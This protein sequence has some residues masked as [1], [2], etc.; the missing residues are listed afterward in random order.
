MI[1]LEQHI[2][3]LL[4]DHDYVVV[5]RFGGFMARYTSARFDEAEDRLLPPTRSLSFNPR[6]QLNDGLLVQSYMQAYGTDFP[7]ANRRLERD[8]RRT[9]KQLRTTGCLEWEGLGVFS[10]NADDTYFFTPD[11]DWLAAPSSYGLSAFRPQRLQPSASVVLVQPSA[12]VA[13]RRPDVYELRIGRTWLRG[14]VAAA[15][16]I[17]AFFLLSTPAENT[18]VEADNYASLFP[19][20]VCQARPALARRPAPA[21][22]V[23][24][25]EERMPAP[26]EADSKSS[27]KLA[28]VPQAPSKPAVS[29]Q[30][31]AKR[32]HVVVASVRSRAEADQL[33]QTLV[34]EGH[35]DASVVEGDGRIRVSLS[36]CTDQSA[37]YRRLAEVRQQP[38]FKDAWLLVR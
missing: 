24:V 31:T 28:E 22:P 20:P 38:S 37:A 19:A 10:L 36:S 26:A 34:R 5:P 23:K 27:T 8:V 30:I 33:V 18:Y 1:A 13:S 3:R 6:L 2:A 17:I 32:Y 12:A 16:T 14:I 35:A 9:M 11:A 25:R 4:L 7:D 29:P 15:V 21:R